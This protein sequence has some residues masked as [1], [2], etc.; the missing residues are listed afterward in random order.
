M[1]EI[2]FEDLPK[3]VAEVLDNQQKILSMLAESPNNQKAEYITRAQLKKMLNIRSDVT[4]IEWEKKG[5][6]QPYRV[7]K[8]V[9]Y[10]LDEVEEVLRSF[11]RK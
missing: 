5:Q 4:V 3:K 8:R 10:R 11:D 2:T 6:L 9:L 7:G 1:N